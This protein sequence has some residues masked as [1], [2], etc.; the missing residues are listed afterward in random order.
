M[1]RHPSDNQNLSLHTPLFDRFESSRPAD[2]QSLA[3][4]IADILGARR[5]TPGP[6]PGILGWGL[7]GIAGLSPASEDHR[8]RMASV[9]AA[10]I[11][12]FE[13]R[14]AGV[15][16]APESGGGDFSFTVSA[17]LVL[18]GDRAVA[19]RILAPRRGGA[20]GADV[21]VLGDRS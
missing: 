10:A 2:L 18:E 19:L 5:A 13:P 4:D 7:P 1:A 17:N 20:L 6:A 15:R 8:Q 9:I 14:L 12:R 21:L 16:V 11:N 3:R